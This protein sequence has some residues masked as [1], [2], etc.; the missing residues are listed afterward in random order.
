MA[1][2]VA[3]KECETYENVKFWTREWQ[4]RGWRVEWRRTGVEPDFVVEAFD[5]PASPEPAKV[6]TT[7]RWANGG[8]D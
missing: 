6:L 4:A 7:D 2:P 1:E 3:R 8:T 5:T